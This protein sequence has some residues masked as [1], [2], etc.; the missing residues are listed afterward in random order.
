MHD[1]ACTQADDILNPVLREQVRY[2]K[3][4]KEGNAE[5]CEL[6]EEYAEKKAKRYAEERK[7]QVKLE[8][9]KNLIDNT[10]LSLEDIAKNV[11]LPLAT[12]EELSHG[13]TA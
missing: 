11:K 10:N 2:L 1:F 5:M 3:E 6:V 7:M 12:V 9:P 8:L 13:R 4:S